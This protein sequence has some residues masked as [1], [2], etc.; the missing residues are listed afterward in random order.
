MQGELLHAYLMPSS[1]QDF[2]Q[3]FLIALAANLRRVTVYPEKCHTSPL[4]QTAAFN[5]CYSY[6][7]EFQLQTLDL[8]GIDLKFDTS[9]LEGLLPKCPSLSVLK[10]GSNSNKAVLALAKQYCPLTV[11]HITERQ[12]WN[13]QLSLEM[14]M[15]LFFN[16][17]ETDPERLLAEFRK[18][19]NPNI[20]ASWPN[21]SDLSTGYCAVTREFFVLAWIVFKKLKYVH[22]SLTNVNACMEKYLQLRDKVPDLGPLAIGEYFTSAENVPNVVE[23]LIRVTCDIENFSIHMLSSGRDEDLYRNFERLSEASLCPK[24]VRL[25]NMRSI[26]QDEP[27]RGTFSLFGKRAKK[28]Q[29]DGAL[30]GA[31]DIKDLS[32][33]LLDFPA[34]EELTLEFRHGLSCSSEE[35]PEHIVFP[36]VT[37]LVIRPSEVNAYNQLFQILPHIQELVF[38]SPSVK[39]RKPAIN[40][41]LLSELR[42]LKIA[43]WD[44]VHF[45]DLLD[46][47]RDVLCRKR[48]KLHGPSD[49]LSCKDIKTLLNSGWNYFPKSR[50][51][52]EVETQAKASFR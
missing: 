14:L 37:S 20:Q 23:D 13:K 50:S 27:K 42:V 6:C 15:D 12:P 19:T 46:V 32:E 11:L 45:S 49:T 18:G 7:Q 22:S 51:T 39:I 44:L 9:V 25:V 40:F 28:L 41:K 33:L 31:V 21:L 5:E 48:F 35:L 16:V 17:T 52:L 47:P 3:S 24:A 4:R 8:T 43:D 26:C 2:S 30:L 34:V 36:Q 29:L 10:L 1:G 38:L